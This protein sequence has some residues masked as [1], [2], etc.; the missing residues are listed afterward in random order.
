[1]TEKELLT[2]KFILVDMDDAQIS[3]EDRPI[4]GTHALATCIGVLLYNEEKKL[5]IVAHVSSEPM[6]T[7]DKIFNLII[8]YK[9]YNAK[10]K[11]LIIPGYY[12]EHYHVKELLEEHFKDFTQFD[13][14]EISCSDIKTIEEETSRQFAF[15]ASTGKFV[16]DKVLYGVDYYMINPNCYN[17]DSNKK[18]HR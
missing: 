4:I 7:I 5:A 11:Y 18:Q 12:E 8:K 17:V 15:D 14:N 10:L 1:M 9:L 2:K 13:E 6:Q 16:T 3:T